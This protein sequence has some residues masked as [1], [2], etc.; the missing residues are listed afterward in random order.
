MIHD[1]EKPKSEVESKGH[2]TTF[3]NDETGFFV[4]SLK[5]RNAVPTEREYLKQGA[6]VAISQERNTKLPSYS[7]TG[8]LVPKED[9]WI[10]SHRLSRNY[11]AL[12]FPRPTL[13]NEE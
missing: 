13:F 4:T 8:V 2:L 9:G 12:R 5:N 1:G 10:P 11:Q 6:L 7:I 3:P